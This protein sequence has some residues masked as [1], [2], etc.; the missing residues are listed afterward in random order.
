M[1][2]LGL[3]QTG[4]TR[5]SFSKT[6]TAHEQESYDNRSLGTL[7]LD[8]LACDL[9]NPRTVWFTP[10]KTVHMLPT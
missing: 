9:V 8:K 10:F 1:P 6:I 3:C 7:R 4:P 2:A 5:D